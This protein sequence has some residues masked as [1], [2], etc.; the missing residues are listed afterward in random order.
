MFIVHYHC[1]EA[2]CYT[3]PK[4]A[5]AKV[6]SLTSNWQKFSDFMTKLSLNPGHVWLETV[7]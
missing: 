7:K 3:Q 6:T 2:R 5:W 1:G 4:R